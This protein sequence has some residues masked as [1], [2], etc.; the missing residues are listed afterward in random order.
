MTDKCPL[1][2]EDFEEW[3]NSLH[4][5]PLV[6]LHLEE[7]EKEARSCLGRTG[8]TAKWHDSEWRARTLS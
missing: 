6:P 4:V 7:S 3:T 5:K 8:P 2:L 1:A